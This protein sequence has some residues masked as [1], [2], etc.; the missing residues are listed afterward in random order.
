MN[1]ANRLANDTSAACSNASRWKARISSMFCSTT[2]APKVASL[3]MI[4]CAAMMTSTPPSTTRRAVMGPPP[5]AA[6][7]TREA[8][9]SGASAPSPSNSRRMSRNQLSAL[10][11]RVRPGVGGVAAP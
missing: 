11:A 10:W 1:T 5:K 9:A 6:A 3:E 7:S 2:T 4:G 8:M